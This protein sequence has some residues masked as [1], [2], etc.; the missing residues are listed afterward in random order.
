MLNTLE[1]FNSLF[2]WWMYAY[3]HP[4]LFDELFVRLTRDVTVE[5]TAFLWRLAFYA[6]FGTALVLAN[7]L[8]DYAKVRMVVEDRRSAI[9]SVGA[10]C[11]FVRRRFWRVGWLYLLNLLAQLILARLWLQVTPGAA[12]S[13][14]VALL[15][16]ELY[17][18]LRVWAR[19]GF[20][21]SEVVFFQGELAHAQYA[22]A[23]EL[24]WPDS[25]AV[26]SLRH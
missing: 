9:S 3:V 6:L 18:V 22:A 26:E 7:V 8:F 4:W 25:P 19:L 17:L 10:A 21:A 1:R 14:W 12:A 15:A 13:I 5:R 16:S 20:L 2:Y 11:R 23:P 24:V